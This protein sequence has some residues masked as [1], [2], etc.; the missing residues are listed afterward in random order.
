LTPLGLVR[1]AEHCYDDG[2]AEINNVEGFIRQ[3]IG[4][5]EYMYWQYQRLMP[6]LGAENFWGSAN[7]LPKFFWNGRTRMN[8]LSQVIQRVLDQ[9]YVHHI[10]RLMLLSNFC[11]LAEIHP[12]QVYDWF[13]S[14]F[15]DAYE[16]VMAPNVYGMGLYAD[17]GQ[18]ATKPY[19]A[20]ANYINKMSDYCQACHFDK[21]Q[22]TGEDACPFNFL[23]WHFLLKHQDKLRKNYRMARMLHNLRFLDDD[24]KDAVQDQA[25]RFIEDL[26]K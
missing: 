2:T 3:V 25:Q 8:C 17:G 11:L 22:R 7:A 12:D 9:G 23:Y 16:W 13:S 18:I 4:W 6:G 5:R 14:A 15:I 26:E 19:I 10:E 1:A 21:N 24:E 20:S